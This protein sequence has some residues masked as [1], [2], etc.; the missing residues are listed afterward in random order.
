M[1]LALP[2]DRRGWSL[3]I[4]NES[5]GRVDFLIKCRVVEIKCYEFDE[6]T[7]DSS[8]GLVLSLAAELKFPPLSS[9]SFS[10]WWWRSSSSHTIRFS[11]FFE[12]L[13][14]SLFN[15][16]QS[17]RTPLEIFMN[18]SFFFTGRPSRHDSMTFFSSKSR[19]PPV[20]RVELI[21]KQLLHK[22]DQVETG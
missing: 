19:P 12:W 18:F 20:A 3:K 21:G 5:K 16:G 9:S 10:P 17:L 2:L 13:I 8:L 6:E 4:D 14:V 1:Q 7:F 15:V 11:C 22:R